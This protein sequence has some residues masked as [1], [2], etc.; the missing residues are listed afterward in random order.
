MEIKKSIYCHLLINYKNISLKVIESILD[1]LLNN[2]ELFKANE[3][4]IILEKINSK[5]LFELFLNKL[6]KFI[7]KEEEL[8]NQE[9]KI[10][11][12]ELL[13][14]IIE[15][16]LFDKFNFEELKKINYVKYSLQNKENILKK[17]KVGEIYYNSLKYID[18]NF[19]QKKIFEEK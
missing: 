4:F 16:K 6:E 3:I 10:K 17:I 5:K 2:I 12:F 18:S 1:Y 7:I 9:R 14:G 11:S 13:E 8:F 19:E 15:H